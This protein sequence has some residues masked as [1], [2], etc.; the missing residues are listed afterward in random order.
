[1][2]FSDLRL[3]LLTFAQRWTPDTLHATVLL[4]PSGDPTQPLFAGAA[5]FAGAAIRLRAA[6]VPG[7][8]AFPGLG[9]A[10]GPLTLPAPAHAAA[11]FGYLKTRFSPVDTTAGPP[12]PPPPVSVIRKALPQTYLGQQPPGRSPSPFVATAD[13]FGCAVRGQL[14]VPPP[15]VQPDPSWG[16]V[17]S[18]G[19]R[20]PPLADALGLRYAIRVGVQDASAFAGGG[21]LFV[22]LDPADGGT[23][24][25]AAWAAAPDAVKVYAARLPAL[26]G[27]RRAIFTAM[28]FGVAN[29]AA[30]PVTPDESLLDIAITEAEA[31]D[32]GFA[33][34]VH[35]RQPDTLDAHIDD[36]KT[37]VNAATDAGI[38]LGWDDEQVLTWHNRQVEIAQAAA[39]G[40]AI[41]LESPLGVGGYRIDVREPVPGE[42]PA[43][44][45]KGWQTLMAASGKVPAALHGEVKGFDGELAIEP[46]ASAASTATGGGSRSPEYWL[47]L[48]FAQWRGTPLGSRDDT[49]HLLSGGVAAGKAPAVVPSAFT[50]KRTPALL[51]GNT[52]EI[53]V[54]LADASGGGPRV[55]DLPVNESIAERARVTF[56]RYVPPKGFGV[57]TSATAQ[58]PFQPT[59]IRLRRPVIGYPEALFTPR[60]GADPAVRAATRAAMLAQLGLGADGSP[61]PPGQRVPDHLTVG[62]PDPDVTAVEI[63][64]EV[65]ALAHDTGQDVSADGVFT[66]VYT[67]RRDVPPLAAIAAGA[68]GAVSPADTVA[69]VAIPPLRLTYVDID[70][71]AALSA[72][73]AGPLPIPRAR[74][75]RL[76]MTPIAQGP[77]GYFGQIDPAAGRPQ[78][79]RGVSSHLR[80]H[81]DPASESTALFAP[82]PTG[83]PVLEA[84]F[85]QPAAAGDPIAPMMSQLAGALDLVADGLTLRAR[86]GQRVVFGASGGFKNTIS[87]DGSAFTFATAAEVFRK[88]TVA[89]SFELARDWTWRGLGDDQVA[90]QSGGTV[91]G[92]ITVPRVASAE[93]LAGTPDRTATRLVFIDGIDPAVPDAADGFT[94]RP[95]YQ[96]V[97]TIP[98]DGV[99]ARTVASSPAALRLPVVIPPAGLP[100]LVSA[101]YALSPY[102]AAADYSSTSPRTRN[103]WLK[104]DAPPAPGDGLFARVLAYAPDPL[105]YAERDLLLAEPA[106]EPAIQL[107]PESVRV[108]TPGQPRDDDGLEAMTELTAAAGD[109]R[110]FLLP[111]PPDVPPGD[112]RL[113]G[114][115]TYELRF[116][117]VRPWSTA[118]GRFGRPLRATG[119]QHPAP[120]LTCAASWRV[121]EVPLPF[122]PGAAAALPARPPGRAAGPP[123]GVAEIVID[124]FLVA[125]A[126]YATPVLDG[127]R[128]GDGFPRT[129]LGFLLYAQARQADGSGYRNVLLAHRGAARV[130]SQDRVDYGE[131]TFE[132]ADVTAA[133]GGLGLPDDVQVSVL[134]VEFYSPGGSVGAQYVPGPAA[135]AAASQRAAAAD[136]AFDPFGQDAFGRRRI[137]RT[138]PLVSV[139]PVC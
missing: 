82:L 24:Y 86:P 65:R 97:A 115:W 96:L 43:Q 42:T 101:G 98:M 62:V 1:M 27:T 51:Y 22:T 39:T 4:V 81:A 74:D 66:A 106:A 105:L 5:P 36:G 70:D 92:T 60:Y 72:P 16:A 108:I 44:R 17:I 132:Q 131:A 129:E 128:V 46:T 47:P 111:L 14:T 102:Q 64:L 100:R 109:P 94:D 118:H 134:A 63:R 21:W 50:G 2:A 80:L 38:Q 89:L 11:V 3:A 133:L 112:P 69:D 130:V 25:A 19:L 20:N 85:F 15:T 41:A 18:H 84:L 107:D 23:G 73:P 79:T 126:P 28:L 87:P 37:N 121:V 104:L 103:L 49:P 113:F 120:P 61:L 95:P 76:V 136:E 56:A 88:W 117:H 12:G 135:L 29:P 99:A 122:G 48:Y 139:Q 124:H 125:T 78:P 26:G 30:P 8:D 52:Y 59:E 67:T 10:S 32:D 138:S 6:A 34:L 77:P 7:L 53:R 54:R 90:V 110:T 31:Y 116:G 83:K 137:L 35:A 123:A 55:H 75:V 40:A 57:T 13:E 127:R 93:S 33:K 58:Q 68:G 114:I 91:I 9:A 71:V 119:V 45:N